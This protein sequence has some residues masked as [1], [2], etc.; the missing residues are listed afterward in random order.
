MVADVSHVY[1]LKDELGLVSVVATEAFL[2]AVSYQ[3]VG[4]DLGGMVL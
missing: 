1:I 2:G 3:S 4:I